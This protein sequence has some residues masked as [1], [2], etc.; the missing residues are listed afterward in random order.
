M[1]PAQAIENSMAF[2][3]GS[4]CMEKYVKSVSAMNDLTIALNKNHRDEIARYAESDI[5]WTKN[6]QAITSR[7]VSSRIVKKGQIYQFEFGK[8]Y[9]PEM[10]YEHRGLVIGVSGKLIY[11]LPICSYNAKIAEHKNAIHPVDNPTG[12][13]NYF[14]LKS[15]EFSFLTHD[16][17]LK[18]NDIRTL[19]FARIKYRQNNGYLDPRSDTYKAIEQL[20]NIKYFPEYARERDN[21]KAENTAMQEQLGRIKQ[22]L[23][24]HGMDND[25]CRKIL[26]DEFDEE[27]PPK[28]SE[29]EHTQ[30]ESK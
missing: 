30:K 25:I 27:L 29:K 18:L 6:K 4:G 22:Y 8:N 20:A 12:K 17:V 28:S 2:F 7:A 24:S 9:A 10:S 3:L 16:S 19:S 13:G 23:K 1:Y 15:S 26:E 14:L 11:A 21:L 5:F